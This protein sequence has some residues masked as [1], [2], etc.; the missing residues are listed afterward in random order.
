MI[1]QGPGGNDSGHLFFRMYTP[2]ILNS[3]ALTKMLAIVEIRHGLSFPEG[4]NPPDRG[5]HV[6]IKEN[7]PPYPPATVAFVNALQKS[8]ITFVFQYNLSM[9]DETIQIS[10]DPK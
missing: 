8:K 4:D 1:A 5:L 6:I 9:I 3:L 7:Q 2:Q 10:I